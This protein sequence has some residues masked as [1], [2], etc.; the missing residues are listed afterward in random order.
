MVQLSLSPLGSSVLSTVIYFSLFK[1]PVTIAELSAYCHFLK[2][3]DEEVIETVRQLQQDGL[4]ES[5]NGYYYLPGESANIS[6][7]ITGEA[8]APGFI[9]KAKSYSS[10][11]ALFPFVRAVFISGSLSKGYMDEK[12]D[13]DY[14][15][16]TEPKRLWLCRTLLV[17]YKKLIL[18]NSHKHFCVNYFIDS[19]NLEIPDKNIFTATEL[20]FILP[21]YNGELYRRFRK[22]NRWTG[23]FYPNLHNEK[24]AVPL[25]FFEHGFR[26][27]LEYLFKGSFGEMLDEWC[28]RTTIRYWKKKFRDF[29]ESVFDMEL[30]S[31]KNVS[32]HHPQGFQR[33]ILTM[34]ENRLNQIEHTYGIRFCH[35]VK[36]TETEML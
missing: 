12:S 11:I 22:T 24:R 4:L 2:A 17:L 13:I 15:I 7:R 16:I 19:A 5:D 36:L 23:D 25:D 21:M 1:H 20:V 18:L 31:K 32:K 14:F 26:N 28:F 29:D 33:K 34:Y 35:D 30:R 10:L 6:R 9:K 8:R 3:S 27:L